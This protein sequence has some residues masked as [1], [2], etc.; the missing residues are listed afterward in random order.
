MSEHALY[1]PS[2]AQKWMD[3][4]CPGSLAMEEAVPSKSSA[5]AA[6]GTAAHTLAEW[7]FLDVSHNARAYLG[8]VI[9]V[10][11]EDATHSITV[12]EDMCGFVQDFVDGVLERIEEYKLRDDVASVELHIEQ[13]V[14]F[15]HIVKKDNQFG[16]VDVLIVVEY[17]SGDCLLSVEDLKYGMGVPVYAKQNKQLK[18]YGVAALHEYSLLHRITEINTVIH[19]V[20]LGYVSEHMYTTD[21][22]ESFAKE[23][24]YSADKCEDAMDKFSI[25]ACSE[26]FQTM[27]L[28]AGT[29]CKKGF[30]D[31]RGEC[32]AYTKFALNTV[33]D[34]FEDLD[35]LAELPREV[36][37]KID[38]I[39]QGLI[40]VEQLNGL[41]NAVDAVEDWVKAMRGR[42]H[43]ELLNGEEM[44]DYILTEGKKGNA[45]WINSEEAESSLRSMRVKQLDMYS[46]KLISP[47]QARKLDTIKNSKRKSNRLEKMITRAD[48]KPAV[49]RRDSGKKP[50]EIAPVVDD[51]E[52]LTDDNFDDLA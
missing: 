31:A 48:G 34:D 49:A 28:N 8:R 10:K 36:Q 22:L 29:H 12:S 15:S 21:E 30:C 52:D 51:F 2:G 37:E 42:T 45:S 14:D 16:T 18:V 1:S 6:E 23:M 11:E 25:E 39:D 5:F 35:D 7:T 44:E 38:A 27:Y 50:L 47:T 20:R 9:E 43:A 13:R 4:G 24:K 40:S 41:M 26:S 32:P 19:M 33:L 3:G 46:Q 17:T